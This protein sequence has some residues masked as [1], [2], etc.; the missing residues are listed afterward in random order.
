MAFW[1]FGRDRSEGLGIG[2]LAGVQTIVL[3]DDQRSVFRRFDR[4][5]DVAFGRR[6]WIATLSI[7]NC[8]ET[9]YRTILIALHYVSVWRYIASRKKTN[10]NMSS[11]AVSKV[12]AECRV[13]VPVV[14]PVTS[15][16]L[17]IP[18]NRPSTFCGY[19]EA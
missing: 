12:S 16:Q 13:M 14:R 6:R 19:V 1:A 5:R 8:A 9:T 15:Q 4:G 7:R 2:T 10:L 18:G 11:F 17:T 3:V